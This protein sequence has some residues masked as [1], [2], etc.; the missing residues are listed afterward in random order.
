MK[1]LFTSLFIIAATAFACLQ[2]CRA[3]EPCIKAV[4]LQIANAYQPVGGFLASFSNPAIHDVYG[5]DQEYF[6]LE[7]YLGTFQDCS[8]G[9]TITISEDPYTNT[10][11]YPG[12]QGPC[13]RTAPVKVATLYWSCWPACDPAQTVHSY[14]I[15][16]PP[17][18]S[19]IT[20]K[21]FPDPGSLCDII[22]GCINY[23]LCPGT[24][25]SGE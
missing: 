25:P 2:P 6:N 21:L 9:V 1:K 10:G 15:M 7:N 4:W 19:A 16:L 3:A 24:P 11:T 12:Y 22:V 5:G 14:D 23:T 18:N 20:F 13:H 17:G 8:T